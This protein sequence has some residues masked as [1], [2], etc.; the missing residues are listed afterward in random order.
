[1]K[2]GYRD[3][4]NKYVRF[5]SPFQNNSRRKFQCGSSA[6]KV[7]Y[8]FTK[9]KESSFH[10]QLKTGTTVINDYNTFSSNK[11]FVEEVPNVPL[12]GRLSQ[13]IKL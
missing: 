8:L 1:M 2:P 12:A 6:T 4:H 3:Q 9:Y 5:Q 11:L 13:F 7:K 10:Q